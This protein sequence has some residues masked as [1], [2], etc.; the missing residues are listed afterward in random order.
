M[1]QMQHNCKHS[2]Q[3]GAAKEDAGVA[4]AMPAADEAP[5]PAPGLGRAAKVLERMANQNTYDDIARDF[6]FW[7]DASDQ[8][9]AGE[10]SLLPLWRFTTERARKKACTALCWSPKARST[11]A[12]MH[13]F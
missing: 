8:F 7:N 5:L 9:K 1:Q 2:L 4:K 3:G 11:A 10:G 13:W 6:K 12:L